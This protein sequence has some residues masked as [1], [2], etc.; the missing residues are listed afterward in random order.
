MGPLAIAALGGAIY[1]IYEK[2]KNP[3]WSPFTRLLATPVD[4]VVALEKVKVTSVPTPSSTVALDPHMTTD[5]V[6]QVNQTLTSETDPKKIA[7][8]AIALGASGH[9]NSAMALA[10]KANAVGEA[11]AT[12]AHDVDIH[13][14]QI[15]AAQAIPSGPVPV[16]IDAPMTAC[17]AQV[18]LNALTAR[19]GHFDVEG[20]PV[21]L[22][23]TNVFDA[24]TS[25]LIRIFQAEMH[26]PATA[27]MDT[28]TAKA[29]RIAALGSGLSAD[30]GPSHVTGWWDEYGH[31]HHRHHHHHHYPPMVEEVVVPEVIEGV[32]QGGPS[33]VTGW[34]DE[35]GHW[36]HR[37]HHHHHYPPMVEEV[38]VPEVIEGVVQGVGWGPVASGSSGP[39]ATGYGYG[40]WT[41][42]WQHGY[43][44]RQWTGWPWHYGWHGFVGQRDREFERG[45]GHEEHGRGRGREQ[46]G[47]GREQF[48]RGREQF[49]RGRE[50]FG[51]GREHF[52]RGHEQFGEYALQPPYMDEGMGEEM[53]P[54]HHRH[55]RHLTREQL[56]ERERE[57]ERLLHMQRMHH[58]PHRRHPHEMMQQPQMQQPAVDPM[59]EQEVAPPA[60]IP[61]GGG[62]GAAAMAEP[63]IEPDHTSDDVP[64]ATATQGSWFPDQ[65]GSYGHDPL[66][67]YG[68]DPGFGYEPGSLGRDPYGVSPYSWV[69]PYPLVH[70]SNSGFGGYG[71]IGWGGPGGLGGYG[72]WGSYGGWGH[73]L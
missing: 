38:V 54:M 37:H 71:S 61:I 12:G 24:D 46:F 73:G 33:H 56:L 30:Q 14:K 41:E 9:D 72:S 27:A 20:V 19:Q 32:V 64:A 44:A 63:A 26:L 5:Q 42:P 17:E 34:W 68:Y 31:W 23:I 21:P 55:R 69:P 51:R 36:H 66:G 28:E 7:A 1:Y 29:L 11:K 22:A 3:A 59:A 18:L 10:A 52:G 48:G 16:P 40:G 25:H 15:E 49:G 53:M 47:R 45:R 4:K 8:H 50:Q 57:R 43:V 35:Y 2:Q 13:L 6:K 65:P 39:V 62:G 58:H 60:G 70:P 67:F